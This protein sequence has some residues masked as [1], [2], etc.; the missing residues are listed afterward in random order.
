MFVY[1]AS[2]LVLRGDMRDLCSQGNVCRTV[3]RDFKVTKPRLEGDDLTR[4]TNMHMV[5]HTCNDPSYELNI[6]CFIYLVDLHN[7]SN[8]DIS[9]YLCVVYWR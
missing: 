4:F 6:L 5:P 3:N 9:N 1:P 8:T 2:S 7:V